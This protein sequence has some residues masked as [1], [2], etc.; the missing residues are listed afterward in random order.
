[1]FGRSWGEFSHGLQRGY[2]KK[3]AIVEVPQNKGNGAGTS[4]KCTFLEKNLPLLDS[5]FF[6]RYKY[7]K[8]HILPLLPPLGRP[9][10]FSWLA[11]G[12]PLTLKAAV[13]GCESFGLCYQL[14]RWFSTDRRKQPSCYS[15]SL[16]LAPGLDI[17]GMETGNDF[18][19]SEITYGHKV[20]A[21]A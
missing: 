13:F 7:L 11:H 6:S 10:D 5:G 17:R 21:S 20:R 15:R 3:N 4:A 8:I 16:P 18:K 14:Q 19:H 1:M 2:S 12:P 9:A